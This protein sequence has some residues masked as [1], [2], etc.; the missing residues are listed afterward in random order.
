MD[1]TE[2]LIQKF[3]NDECSAEEADAV[4]QFLSVH[5]EL[6]NRFLNEEE[7]T[8]TNQTQ[9]LPN[10]LSETILVG[11]REQLIFQP[12][13]PPWWKTKTAKRVSVAAVFV[14]LAI[15]MWIFYHPAGSKQEFVKATNQN[16]NTA[17][18]ALTLP[19]AS[20]WLNNVNNS[21]SVK[22]ILLSD[23]SLV[24][25]DPHSSIQYKTDFN[26]IKRDLYLKG[27]AFF[28]VAKNK[29]KPF[30]VYSGP[31]STTAMGTSFRV[32]AR[33]G[34]HDR[35]TVHLFTGKVLI[36]S[37]HPMQGWVSDI[38]LLPGQK[39]E[40]DGRLM[41]ATVSEFRKQRKLNQQKP[42]ATPIDLVFNNT[43]LSSVINQLQ[44]NYHA[45][46]H[47]SKKDMRGL[48]FTGTVS[49]T[50]SLAVFLKLLANMNG[51]GV[52]EEKGAFILYHP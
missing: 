35:I 27:Q 25:L 18:N 17:A 30:S 49:K 6:M 8:D 43:S 7:W 45:T 48:N 44:D 4:S 51:L 52:R 19:I 15:N 3:F 32:S 26:S 47:Y 10:H 9:E 50:D 21:A 14:L 23:G 39:M 11:L 36:K 33:E 29:S 40:F 34:M 37:I 12:P 5:P 22:R 1:I 13:P 31:L 16:K 42:L 20:E 46:I 2:D 41:Q 24:L 38:Q 28:E